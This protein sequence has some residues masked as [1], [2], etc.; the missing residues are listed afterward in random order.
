MRIKS[1]NPI[2]FPSLSVDAKEICNDM[3]RILSILGD[4]HS[5][6]QLR[7]YLK[8]ESYKHFEYGFG[9]HHMWVKQKVYGGITNPQVLFVTF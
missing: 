3:S 9:G 5:E 4:S 6:D 7:E 8:G 1:E 2:Q